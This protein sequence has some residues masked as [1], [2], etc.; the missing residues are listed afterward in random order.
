MFPSTTNIIPS[1]A[2][3]SPLC[4]TSPTRIIP[5]QSPSGNTWSLNHPSISSQPFVGMPGLL[6]RP[7]DSTPFGFFSLLVTEQ[8]LLNIVEA[9]YHY[10]SK[11]VAKGKAKRKDLN[12]SK[13]NIFIGLLFHMGTIKMNRIKDY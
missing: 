5:L 12:F 4:V 9:T 3:P 10:A 1:I 11:H 8:F 6:Q 13:F 2:S 7:L